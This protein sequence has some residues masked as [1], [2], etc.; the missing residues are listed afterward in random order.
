MNNEHAPL[1]VQEGYDRWSKIYDDDANPLVALEEPVVH[2]WL[3]DVRGLQG[4]ANIN[5]LAMTVRAGD[6]GGPVLDRT[7]AVIGM[8]TSQPEGGP[9]LPDGVGFALNAQ[10][11]IAASTDAGIK[12]PAPAKDGAESLTAFQLSEKASG[13]T[14]LVSCWE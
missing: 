12:L 2:D 13:M 6:A 5:R 10:T 14:V 9:V 11:V 7:G 1:Q 3:A 8:L 4:E